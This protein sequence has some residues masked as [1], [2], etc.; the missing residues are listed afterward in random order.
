MQQGVVGDVPWS[1]T[2][3]CAFNAVKHLGGNG[4]R[5]LHE[6]LKVLTTEEMEDPVDGGAETRGDMIN[7]HLSG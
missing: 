3:A 1:D 4:N 2:P 5:I 6:F 7:E